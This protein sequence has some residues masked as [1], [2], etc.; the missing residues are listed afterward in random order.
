[1][2]EPEVGTEPRTLRQRMGFILVRIVVPTWILVGAMFK[3]LEANPGLLPRNIIAAADGVGMNLD[4]LLALL[5][6]A[7]ISIASGIMLLARRAR[8]LAIAMLSVFCLVLIG[9]IIVGNGNCGC[10]GARSPSPWVMLMID[11]TMLAGVLLCQDASPRA[12]GG[13]TLNIAAALSVLLASGLSFTILR[14]DMHAPP[15]HG[16]AVPGAP[17]DP[18]DSRDSMPLPSYWYAADLSSWIGMPVQDIDLFQFMAHALPD[19]SE[20]TR[21]VVFYQRTCDHCE[22]MFYDDLVGN[23]ALAQYVTA[24]EIPAEKD[25]LTAAGAWPM[26][27]TACELLALPLGCNWIIEAPLAVRIENGIVQ[28]ATEGDHAV[29]LGLE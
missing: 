27:E 23:D 21:Y 7:E 8:P 29:C 25:V 20:G 3:L 15:V 16:H 26:P 10:L 1:M 19:S 17:G 6:T 28:C 5:I 9:E 12:A 13:S 14:P 18:S 2:A 4:W 24:V 11:G 22:A